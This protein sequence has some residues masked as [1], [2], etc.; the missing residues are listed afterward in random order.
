MACAWGWLIIELR[1][2]R[3]KD[4]VKAAEIGVFLMLL[5]F[6]AENLG[7]LLGLWRSYGSVYFV[8]AAPIEVM[9]LALIG[10]TAWALYQPKRFNA[11]YSLADIAVFATFGTIGEHILGAKGLIVYIGGWNSFYAFLGYA[12]TWAILHSILYL[13]IQTA[14]PK[15]APSL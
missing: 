13:R 14:P 11:L 2:R 7:K 6:F 15:I 4:V 10:G 1:N 8:F 12:V 3:D 9:F 5:D